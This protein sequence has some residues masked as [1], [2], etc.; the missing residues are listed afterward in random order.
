VIVEELAQLVMQV[1]AQLVLDVIYHY[2]LT[3]VMILVNVLK[4]LSMIVLYVLHAMKLVVNV[5]QQG[6]IN[7]LLVV[8]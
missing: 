8:N 2:S 6:T 5:V 1:E 4:E 3:L 7:V